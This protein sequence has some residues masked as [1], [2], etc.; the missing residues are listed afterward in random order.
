MGRSTEVVDILEEITAAGHD[1]LITAFFCVAAGVKFY[2]QV[3]GP[4][5]VHLVLKREKDKKD[6]NSS[7]KAYRGK[8]RMKK[9]ENIL[10][11]PNKG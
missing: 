4:W 7:K 6:S 3:D 5:D 11:Y 2:R 10:A 9:R 8:L 1:E